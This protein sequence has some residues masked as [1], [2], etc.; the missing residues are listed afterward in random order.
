[1][2][3]ADHLSHPD[4]IIPGQLEQVRHLAQTYRGWLYQH[5]AGGRLQRRISELLNHATGMIFQ[6]P[7][8]KLRLALLDA[9]ADVTNLAAYTQQHYVPTL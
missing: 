8:G 5:G 4:K 7:D 1:M 3:L 2:P 9:T 6:A